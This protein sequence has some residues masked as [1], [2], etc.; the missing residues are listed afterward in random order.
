MSASLLTF[1][2]LAE[3]LKGTLRHSWLSQT[4]RQES[5][6][7]H[8][9]MMSLLALT[10]FP[11]LKKPVDQLKVLKMIIIH[12]LAEAVT[13]DVPVWEGQ[14][15][16]AAKLAAE[17]AAME[18]LLAPLDGETRNE[19]MTLWQEYEERQSFESKLVKALDT[20]DVIAQHNAAATDTWDDNDYLWQLSPLQDSFFDLDI[21]LRNIKHELDA[22]SIA[23]AKAAGNLGKLNQEELKK[24]F[25]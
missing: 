9:W 11:Q 6:A 13:Q 1:Y 21:T 7:E 20:L 18:S 12:D 10:I 3:K 2:R 5:V 15:H 22:W 4:S 24:R 25:Q 23:Q 8:T 14:Q 17:K 19:L 16:K